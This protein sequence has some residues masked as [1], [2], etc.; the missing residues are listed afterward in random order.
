M[1]H[2]EYP[3]A[4]TFALFIFTS[5]C[6]FIGYMSGSPYIKPLAM[7]LLVAGFAFFTY[8]NLPA[9][10]LTKV[11]QLFLRVGKQRPATLNEGPS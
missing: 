9:H 6:I 7:L 4:K 11:R 5:I 8:N 1:I 3:F 2:I 10:Y